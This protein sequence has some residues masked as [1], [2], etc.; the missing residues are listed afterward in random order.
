MVR[1]RAM[2]DGVQVELA[3]D[4]GVDVVEGDE[5]R[6]RQVIFN[7]LSNAVKFTP[8]G[9]LVVVRARTVRESGRDYA[10]ISVSDS[11]CGISPQD[12]KRLFLPFSQLN[13]HLTK[14]HEGTGLGLALCR[15]FVD[16]HHGRIGVESTPGR[17]STFTFR[18]P[19]RLEVESS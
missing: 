8:D 12:Q 15:S 9:G 7:L 5:R 19:I 17:G 13:H 4:P 14:D 3:A 18:I 11:G 6:I 16:M 2:K 10:E 1:E